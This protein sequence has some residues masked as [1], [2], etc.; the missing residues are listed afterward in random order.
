MNFRQIH[1]NVTD[2]NTLSPLNFLTCIIDFSI[3]FVSL[4]SKLGNIFVVFL[5]LFL[6]SSF[7][8]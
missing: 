8:K 6:T 7:F 4:F 5:I 2:G 1:H 3:Q